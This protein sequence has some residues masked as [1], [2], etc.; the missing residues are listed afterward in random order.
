MLIGGADL[1]YQLLA[2]GLIDEPAVDVMPILFGDG[3][4]LFDGDP[5]ATLE[6]VSV[7][8]VG[9]RTCLLYR[10]VPAAEAAGGPPAS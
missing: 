8:E 10:V 5:P 9:V 1:F 2:A 7:Q 3:V 6:K 4:R